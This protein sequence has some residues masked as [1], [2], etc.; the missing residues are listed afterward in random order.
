MTWYSNI[1]F[2]V[3]DHTGAVSSLTRP[4]TVVAPVTT[5]LSANVPAKFSANYLVQQFF[6][7]D[8]PA[9]VKSLTFTLSPSSYS[10]VGT[11]YLRAGSPTTRN[12]NCQSVFVRSGA[13]AL[14]RFRTR[15]TGTYYGTVNPNSNLAN[16]TLSPL[17][18]NSPVV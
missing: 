6:S 1:S 12:A 2:A 17:T 7:L 18:Q 3:T 13:A 14:H 8:I 15:H 9:G 4:F 11:L 16:V 5:E 10:D